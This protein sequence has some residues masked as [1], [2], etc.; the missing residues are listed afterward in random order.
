MS[1]ESVV[2]E[3]PEGGETSEYEEALE[4]GYLGESPDPKP[5]EDYTVA[6]VTKTGDNAKP[7]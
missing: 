3:T 2:T 6:G 7:A 1:E 4:K 5:N